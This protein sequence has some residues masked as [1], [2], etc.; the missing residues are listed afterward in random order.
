MS[1]IFEDYKTGDLFKNFK[2]HP[3][4]VMQ[5]SFLNSININ[6]LKIS[7]DILKY[8]NEHNW[9]CYSNIQI[10]TIILILN[11]HEKKLNN[12]EACGFLLG[13]NTGVGKGRQ[14]CGVIEYNFFKGY[15]KFIWLTIN[16]SLLSSVIRDIN[17]IGLK[18]KI[19]ILELPKTAEQ[20][21]LDEG[22]LF[23]TYKNLISK[24]RYEQVKKWLGD[25]FNSVIVLDECHSGKNINSKIGITLNKLEK[26]YKM[27][28]F[29][30]SSATSFSEPKHYNYMPRL[31]LWDQQFSN[32]FEN[33]KNCIGKGGY[34]A[35]ELVC[36]NLK[37]LGKYCSRSLSFENVNFSIEKINLS[38]EETELYN[39]YCDVWCKLHKTKS[40]K[41]L[42]KYWNN[43]QKFF[44]H[45]LLCLKI[46]KCVQITK[47]ALKNNIAV[48]IGLFST[49]TSALKRFNNDKYEEFSTLRDILLQTCNKDDESENFKNIRESID[50]LKFYKNPL[51]ELIELLGGKDLVAE[52]TGRDK[53]FL[54]GKFVNRNPNKENVKEMEDFQKGSIKGGKDI[55]IISESASTGISLHCENNNKKRLHI[56]LQLPWSA[57][58]ALQQLGRTHRSNQ[59]QPPEYLMLFTD[60]AGE[61]RLISCIS[62]RISMLGAINNG[63]RRAILS[64]SL[65]SNQIF[66]AD[67]FKLC[68]QKIYQKYE[69]EFKKYG[70]NKYIDFK[71]FLNKLL[72]VPPILQNE[73]FSYFCSKY[74]EINNKTVNQCKINFLELNPKSF[75]ILYK[76]NGLSTILLEYESKGIVI[77]GYT[78]PF[79]EDIINNLVSA[80][81][82]NSTINS[83]LNLV[84]IK[85]Q[86]QIN[87]GIWFPD[88]L[89]N[90]IKS[91]VSENLIKNFDLDLIDIKL[92][93]IF[94]NKILKG[95]IELD[96]IKE[97]QDSFL[98][99]L[100]FFN[101]T[102]KE[103]LTNLETYYK[104]NNIDYDEKNVLKILN[105][106]INKIRKK[107]L[108]NPEI[109]LEF[110]IQEL[111]SIFTIPE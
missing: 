77:I 56:I 20:K 47:E 85:F 91:I 93:N 66:N 29:I 41:D 96:F 59:T 80:E 105:P 27:A 65:L 46:K 73:I 14:I 106:H 90:F 109:D 19:K 95:D 32:S 52:I 8:L 74:D 81:K 78:L 63:D 35:A 54:N 102:L 69:T 72:G 13:D 7:D 70:I 51:D 10:E 104:E 30:Y 26:D 89:K 16:K 48:V 76:K 97:N 75:K 62:N 39:Q 111:L 33:F 103:Y 37:S 60:L 98:E 2:K 4:R 110:K 64:S 12:G 15:K 107:F 67:I 71:T 45:F 101:N 17:D 3:S 44:L 50:K 6:H 25:D 31:G 94:K 86:N 21:I 82:I 79:I 22:I 108:M 43:H 28:K 23:I 58:K 42:I 40:K 61:K 57:E 87:I 11:A 88:K 5:A 18:N 24:N 1:E 84:K 38:K 9:E 36:C 34:G 92:R 68:F 49:G 99:Y 83:N 100:K 53:Y 55:A